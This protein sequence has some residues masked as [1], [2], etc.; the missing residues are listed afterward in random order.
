MNTGLGSIGMSA[1]IWAA[2]AFAPTLASIDKDLEDPAG[3]HSFTVTGTNLAAASAIT[4]GGTAGT[5]TG[6]TGTTVT[7]TAPAKTV[8]S[9]YDVIVTTPAGAATLS[10]AILYWDPTQ[11]PN[12]DAYLD[13]RLGV[14]LSGSDVT[15][16]ACQ[17]NG[18]SFVSTA[19]FRPVRVTNVFNSTIPAIRFAPNQWVRATRRATTGQ[20]AKCAFWV[21][22]HTS[23]DTSQSSTAN[24]PLTVVGDSTGSVFSSIGFSGGAIAH[25]VSPAGGAFTLTTKGSGFNDGN[26]RLYGVTHV[27]GSGGNDPLSAWSG[28]TQQGST[29]LINFTPA[30]D[31]WDSVGCG[32]SNL[33]GFDGDLGAVVVLFA[34]ISSTN[35]TRLHKWA[36]I[37]FGAA[38]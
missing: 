25:T 9:A 7:F 26:V 15:A 32:F 4:V 20:A 5:I 24:A 18:T 31:G 17:E 13:S 38:A 27:D 33:D 29:V 10:S 37:V 22:K 23:S 28:V 1:L 2:G 3:G 30:S 35:H 14:S 12:C 21:G 19:S 8:G 16:W 6:T 36:Q 11:I 34:D